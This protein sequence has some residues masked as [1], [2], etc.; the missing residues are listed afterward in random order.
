MRFDNTYL[1]IDLDRIS[2]NFKAIQDKVSVP[3]MAVIKADAYGHGAV[4]VARQLQDSGTPVL[5]ILSRA[6]LK[7]D[8]GELAA[9]V[10]EKLG[11]DAEP[12]SVTD[13]E[14][15]LIKMCVKQ[16]GDKCADESEK[17]NGAERFL[18]VV[19]TIGLVAG[20]LYAVAMLFMGLRLALTGVCLAIV[21][22]ISWAMVKVVL[23]ISNN[24]H[25][26][27]AKMK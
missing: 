8:S 13:E 10:K 2:A 26:I 22:F 1:T 15:E 19:N 14:Y 3:V 27:N 24:L 7:R 21:M 4:Q 11:L 23:N 6:D 18:S 12:I 16:R 5:C 17:R 25:D 20:L 9:A